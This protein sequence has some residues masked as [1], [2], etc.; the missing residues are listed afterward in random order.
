MNVG[1]SGLEV[2]DGSIAESD[3]SLVQSVQATGQ[4]GVVSE[5]GVLITRSDKTASRL[6]KAASTYQMIATSLS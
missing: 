5:G 3:C 1:E 6:G 4:P 2:S